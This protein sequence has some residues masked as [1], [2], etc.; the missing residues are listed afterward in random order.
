MGAQ[1][2]GR[3]KVD[4]VNINRLSSTTAYVHKAIALRMERLWCDGLV[5]RAVALGVADGGG[6]ASSDMAWRLGAY[7]GRSRPGIPT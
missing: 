3:L 4:Y 5:A 2:S 7:S 6:L 1:S